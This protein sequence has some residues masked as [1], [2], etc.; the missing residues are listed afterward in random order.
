VQKIKS[1]RQADG[2]E[3]KQPDIVLLMTS[4]RVVNVD[5]EMPDDAS[6]YVLHPNSYVL[7]ILWDPLQRILALLF[8]LEIPFS[9][10]FHPEFKLGATAAVCTTGG[11]D[12]ACKGV[13]CLASFA[14]HMVCEGAVPVGFPLFGYD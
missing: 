5:T 7:R 9:I 3:L 10:S 14:G 11:Y 4:V 1:E 13:V 6:R 12:A 8:F 2:V